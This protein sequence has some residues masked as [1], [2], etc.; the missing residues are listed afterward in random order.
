V[1]RLNVK[2]DIFSSSII[3]EYAVLLEIFAPIVIVL[4]SAEDKEYLKNKQKHL[5]H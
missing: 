3:T 1:F 5:A 4:S 2:D